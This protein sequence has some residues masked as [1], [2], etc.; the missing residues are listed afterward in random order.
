MWFK[1]GEPLSKV[2]FDSNSETLYFEKTTLN[3]TGQYSCKIMLNKASAYP[4][5]SSFSSLWVVGE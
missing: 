2:W 5:H 3:D 1:G 4:Y